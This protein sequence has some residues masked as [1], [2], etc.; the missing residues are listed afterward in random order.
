MKRRKKNKKRQRFFS[1]Y[2]LATE[3]GVEL[4]R[5]VVCYMSPLIVL[6]VTGQLLSWF[7]LIC[8]IL[9]EVCFFLLFSTEISEI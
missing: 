3:N 7:G 6:E 1:I 4:S 8:R 9:V 2:Y 5:G